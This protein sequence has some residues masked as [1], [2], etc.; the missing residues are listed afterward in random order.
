MRPSPSS[1]QRSDSPTTR[2]AAPAAA[3]A[4]PSR[5]GLREDGLGNYAGGALDDQHAS[6]SSRLASRP[7]RRR[8]AAPTSRSG[9]PPGAGEPRRELEGRPVV[10]TGAEGHHHRTEQPRRSRAPAGR[11]RRARARAPR[12]PRSSSPSSRGRTARG[13]R[14]PAMPAALRRRPAPARRTPRSA[15]RLRQ[16]SAARGYRRDERGIATS[17]GSTTPATISSRPGS[18]PA[19][20]RATLSRP[21]RAS[22]RTGA[23]SSARS[24]LWTGNTEAATETAGGPSPASWR[25]SPPRTASASRLARARARPIARGA[26]PGRPPERQPGD[27]S[28]RGRA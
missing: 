12:S 27:R 6:A 13:R 11:R 21:S 26:R 14:V 24:W 28:G 4:T 25:G 19:S 20:G 5:P 17:S 18:P 15:W 9:P 2:R 7:L 22:R 16:R 23:T 10:E 1:R 3:S 8:S